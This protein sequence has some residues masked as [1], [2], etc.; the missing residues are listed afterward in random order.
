MCLCARAPPP[1][2]FGTFLR[3]CVCVC[4]C[5]GGAGSPTGVCVCLADFNKCYPRE[6]GGGGGGG[7]VVCIASAFDQRCSV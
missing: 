7:A 3:H 2:L 5:G 6:Q 4:V 1:P